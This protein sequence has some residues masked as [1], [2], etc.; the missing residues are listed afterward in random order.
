MISVSQC[1]DYVGLDST[2]LVIGIPP[3]AKHH[4]LLAGYL[5]HLGRGAVVVRDMIRD[6]LRAFLDLGAL[7]R[8]ADLLVV[9]RLLLSNYP[10]ARVRPPAAVGS[11]V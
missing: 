8:A 1:A 9:L 10:Q 11:A 2:E 7:R 4:S 3:S 6:D 5:L